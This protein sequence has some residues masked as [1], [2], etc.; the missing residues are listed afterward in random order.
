MYSLKGK[1]YSWFNG[2]GKD[3]SILDHFISKYLISSWGVTGQLI[4]NKD[5]LDHCLV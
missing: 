4:G 5:I 1:K 3:F 2:D